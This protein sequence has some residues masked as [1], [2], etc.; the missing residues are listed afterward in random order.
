MDRSSLSLGTI[1]I[2]KHVQKMAKR[3]LTHSSMRTGLGLVNCSRISDCVDASI[4]SE[5]TQVFISQ[6]A[7]A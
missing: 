7:P 3:Q 2:V 5:N 6:Y 4:A 1:N